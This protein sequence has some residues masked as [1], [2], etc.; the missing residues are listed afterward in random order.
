MTAA[1]LDTLLRRLAD[2][3]EA[4]DGKAA[5]IKDVRALADRLKPFA[6]LSLAE[7]GEFLVK[8]EAYSR[9]DLEAVFGKKTGS[10][11]PGKAPADPNRVP[12]AVQR[13][14]TLYERALDPSVTPASVDVV[15]NSVETFTKAELEQVAAGCG[16]QQKFKT[17]AAM[18]NAL[19][20]W[21][22]D[23]KGAFARAGV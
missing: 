16:F 5:G 2:L 18:L 14:R 7:F 9:G 4:A 20:K 3:M 8:A 22:L 6:R 11:R 13:L 15:I 12:G 19:Q 23:R 10:A 17:K 1:T 21:V